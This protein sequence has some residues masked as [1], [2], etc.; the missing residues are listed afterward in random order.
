MVVLDKR[1]D[2]AEMA[3]LNRLGIMPTKCDVSGKHSYN[4]RSVEFLIDKR[5]EIIEV[6]GMGAYGL[7]VSAMDKTKEEKVAI[8]RISNLFESIG[9]GKRILREIRLMRYL[10]SE[11]IL[12]I[13]DMEVPRNYKNFN[14][15][16]IISPLFDK[17]L[18]RILRA[19]VELK[20]E[21]VKYFLYQILCGLKYMH[22]ASIL[23]RDLKPANI[24]VQ[25]SCDLVLCDLGLARYIHADSN[26]S[27]NSALTEYVVTRWYRA[28][29]LVLCGDVYGT[30]VDMWACGCILAE[31]LLGRV[32]FP[33]KDFRHQVELICNSIGKPNEIDQKL[34][35]SPQAKHFVNSL[36]DTVSK[37]LRKFFN[38]EKHNPDAIDLI[39]KFLVFNPEKRLTAAQALQ[40]P[41]LAE[42]HEPDAEPVADPND[43]CSWLE[44]KPINGD[45]LD[46][47]QL[48]QLMLKEIAHFRPNDKLFINNPD[49]K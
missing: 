9:D 8:K 49:L 18:E 38:P 11:Q 46:T 47:A 36:S 20:D 7:V 37:P 1:Y 22:S 19:G 2:D 44:P 27:T 28:P 10:K 33:G 12:K 16:Y 6:L 41:Y 48:R 21:H 15:I 43:D 29:E 25:E 24:L 30:A 39:E 32:L 45:E 35:I 13:S 5:Y 40:H 3:R 31:L 42:Y 34:I 26:N 14:E 17:D 4:V 23:H